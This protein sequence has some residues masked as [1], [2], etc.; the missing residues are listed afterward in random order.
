MIMDSA[1]SIRVIATE[2]KKKELFE[3]LKAFCEKNHFACRI[4]QDEPYWKIENLFE[5]E[6]ELSPAPIW[7]Y[8][9]WSAA[10]KFLFEQDFT[11]EW[12][13]NE[14]ISLCGYPA[15]DDCDAY[16]AILHIPSIN[17]VPKPSKTIR[18]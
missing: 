13:Q 15:V 14:D 8:G 11:I 3:R 5:I 18:H 16:F 2:R 1:I 17:F 10:Y 6:I 9:K 4:L 7:N 12:E